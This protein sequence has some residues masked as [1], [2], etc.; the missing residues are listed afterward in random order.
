MM[1][2][3]WSGS[4]GLPQ[5]ECGILLEIEPSGGL[6]QTSVAI[7]EGCDV[8]LTNPQGQVHGHVISCQQ[9]D[10]GYTVDFTV[11]DR[12]PGWYPEYVPPYL[13]SDSSR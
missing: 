13:H 10:Y 3:S 2:V 12:E 7:P 4:E 8:T 5:S 1:K 6:L 11:V 9:D